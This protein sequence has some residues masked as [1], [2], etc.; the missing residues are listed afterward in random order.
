MSLPPSHSPYMHRLELSSRCTGESHASQS[1]MDLTNLLSDKT[2]LQQVLGDLYRPFEAQHVDQIV[3]LHVEGEP[4]TPDANGEVAT[5]ETGAYRFTTAIAGAIAGAKQLAYG[6]LSVIKKKNELK[7]PSKTTI[8]ASKCKR[9][10][11]VDCGDGKFTVE[12]KRKAIKETARVLLVADWISEAESIIAARDALTRLGCDVVGAS[13]VLAT[14]ADV[15][16]SLKSAQVAYSC[17]WNPSYGA[18]LKTSFSASNG[19]S[20]GSGCSCHQAETSNGQTSR[21]R[22]RNSEIDSDPS[23]KVILSHRTAEYQAND[24]SEDRSLNIVKAADE[25]VQ[26]NAVFDG[27]GGSRAVKH[28]RTSLC[29]HILAAVSSRN[30]SDEVSAIVKSAFARS[31]EELKQSLLALPENTRMSKGYCNAGACAVIALFINSVLYIANVG[32]CAAVL[33]KVSKETQGL[34]AIA[35]MSKDDQATGAGI[36][37]VKRVAGSLAMTRAFGD[38]YLKCPELSSAPFKSK[39]P[40]VTSEPSITTVYMDGSE[41]YVILAS[42]GLWDVMTPQEAVHIVDKFG[43]EQSLFFSTA[44]AALIHAALEKIAHRDG[45]MMHELMSMPQGSVR[46]RFHD[47]ITCTVVYIEH[48]NGS[49]QTLVGPSTKE[50]TPKA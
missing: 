40:Y 49:Q 36:I 3:A 34:Q 29:Q 50:S 24:P 44:S 43:P 8:R 10:V 33:G 37:G 1:V 11:N 47:D 30:S 22:P 12:L 5:N 46:R 14:N 27:H 19:S 7:L 45:L 41:K 21:K 25:G 17:S 31:D 38:F 42:D 2:A 9:V 6:E 13:F 4:I 28:L 18:E 23:V 35:V 15:L 48:Q 26:I 16:H 20:S 32:D 39:V